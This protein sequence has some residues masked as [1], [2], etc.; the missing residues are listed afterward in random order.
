[1]AIATGCLIMVSR[2]CFSFMPWD[3]KQAIKH[4]LYVLV[5]IVLKKQILI[6]TAFF[7]TDFFCVKMSSYV[8]LV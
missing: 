8:G 6:S 1:M 3:E 7:E 2:Q 4:D 5:L